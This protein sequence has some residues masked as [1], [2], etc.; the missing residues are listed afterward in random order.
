[1]NIKKK[2]KC[3]NSIKELIFNYKFFISK[4]IK[5]KGWVK[6]FRYNCFIIINDGSTINNLQIFIDKKFYSLVKKINIGISIEVIGVLVLS[7]GKEQNI[8]IYAKKIKIIGKFS[9]EELQ[10]TILQ[11]KTHSFKKLREQA[12]LRFR[13][14]IFS[15]IFRIRHNI[16]FS[17]HKFF[18][19]KHFM[20]INTPIITT[21]DSEGAG[22]M[23][24]VT[25][26]DLKKIPLNEKGE[27]NNNLD[28]FGTST[29]LTVSGQL[30]G[31]AAASGL[32]KIYTFGPTFRAE[33]SN[34]FRHLSEFWM[35]E[36]E[37]SFYKLVH[38]M[39]FAEKLLKYVIKFVINNSYEDLFFLEKKNKRKIFKRL[40]NVL[41]SSFERISYTNA[42]KI[43]KS[44]FQY[45][46]WGE[47]LKS[48]HEKFLAENYFNNPIII[49]NYPLKIKP[50]Y[51]RINN[52]NKTVAAMDIIFPYIGE[53]IG[54]S[55]REERY[56][57]LLKRI[58]ELNLNI[59]SLWWYLN[60][61]RF[62]SVP[63]SGFGLGFERLIQYI[64]N[65]DNIKDVIPFPR[66]PNH[67][68][69]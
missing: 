19:K 11:P 15:S 32:G 17:I 12:Y 43:I 55:Q 22:E 41:E 25:N 53:I 1:M 56:N 29:Y 31:E 23:F 28:F 24:R 33:K 47:D 45:I 49:Y 27:L 38:N 39:N 30:Q 35:I 34:T 62:G 61:R 13:T 4:E 9:H 16:S 5:I 44:R 54:G 2:I 66:Y 60:I 40:N 3:F 63:H 46:N 7:Q 37:M 69:F 51:M 8:E 18:F 52:D 48:E 36:P 10:K 58:L 20:Y 65:I 50:F 42:I 64:T 67:A 6:H 21:Y 14:S 59:K 26:F 68:Y 57:V